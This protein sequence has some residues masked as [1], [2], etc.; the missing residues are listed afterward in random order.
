MGAL[1][2]RSFAA[3]SLVFVLALPLG[4]RADEPNARALATEGYDEFQRTNYVEALA[5]FERA[6]RA[7]PS[8]RLLRA[9]AK[10]LFELRR[11][12]EAVA[13]CDGA[14]AD[15]EGL[16][17]G[18][19][20][21]VNE[22]RTRALGFTGTVDVVVVPPS[23]DVSIDGRPLVRSPDG[24]ARVD[25]GRHVVE[26]SA[27]GYV[28]TRRELTVDAGT[29]QNVRVELTANGDHETKNQSRT[30]A[31]ALVGAGGVVGVTGVVASTLWFVDRTR[32]VEACNEAAARG[33]S[34]D[35]GSTV[36]T[37]RNLSL[38]GIIGSGIIV[39]VSA[40]FF[41][42]LARTPPPKSTASRSLVPGGFVW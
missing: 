26:A 34:C 22:L 5:L 7:E 24:T 42:I 11:Y 13:A 28:M 17:E 30:G 9:I 39:A 25:V 14:L 3:S 31:W 32:A 18:L 4:A 37:E 36:A 41:V 38:S 20:T 6:Y 1:F 19:R 35:N 8:S 10:C 21:D 33:A 29:A 27:P 12:T 40:T 23:A 16:G 2:R 15:P